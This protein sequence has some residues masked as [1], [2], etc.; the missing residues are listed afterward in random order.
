MLSRSG[1]AEGWLVLEL[2]LTIR[3]VSVFLS[4][5]RK[6]AFARHI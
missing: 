3:I 2:A 1:A 4:I 6:Q 5:A